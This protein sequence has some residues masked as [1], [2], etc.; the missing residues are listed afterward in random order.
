VFLA[1]VNA[2]PRLLR[3][4]QFLRPELRVVSLT[5]LNYSVIPSEVACQ[6]VL[7]RCGTKAGGI[8]WLNEQVIPRDLS[9]A[10][11]S[12]QDDNAACVLNENKTLSPLSAPPQ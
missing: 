4:L 6:A 9:T 3:Q 2:D 1:R 11:R 8:P 5:A 10:L 7:P 12:A